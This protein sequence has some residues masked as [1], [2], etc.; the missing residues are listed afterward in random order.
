MTA[1]RYLTLV[2]PGLPWALLRGSGAGVIVALAFAIAL[3]AGVVTTFVWPDLVEMPVTV[4]VWAG[5]P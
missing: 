2:W 5:A 1:F 4:A 3:D